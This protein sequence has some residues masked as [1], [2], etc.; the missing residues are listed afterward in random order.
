MESSCFLISLYRIF[1]RA[2]EYFTQPYYGVEVDMWALGV[3]YHLMLFGQYYFNGSS[4]A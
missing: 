1:F 4:E 3:M 2:P